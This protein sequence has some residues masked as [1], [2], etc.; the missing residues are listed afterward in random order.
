[1]KV[2]RFTDGDM[3]IGLPVKYWAD[4]IDDLAWGQ[5]RQLATLPFAFHHIA[6]MADCHS[7]YG[8]PIG[9]V[10]AADN[11]IVPNAVGVDIG[12]GMRA[13]KTSLLWEDVK[14]YD[15]KKILNS[16]RQLIPVGKGQH[17][18]SPVEKEFL[19]RLHH[20]H[21]IPVVR[22][23]FESARHQFGTL[24]SGN[25]FI[26]IQKGNDG[27][28]WVMLHSGS[29]NVGY[30]VAQ[31]YNQLAQNLNDAWYSSVPKE[32]QLA[33]L[34]LSSEAAYD[35]KNEMEW[36]IEFAEASRKCMMSIIR[37][38]FMIKWP[39]ISF[40]D[41]IDVKHNYARMEHH[42]GRNVMVHRKGAI[43]VQAGEVGI[44]PGSQGTKSYIVHGLGN[45]DS[46]MSA[47]HGAGR[48]MSRSKAKQTLDLEA[49]KSQM[50]AKGIL[51]TVTGTSNLDEAPG[52]YK[53]IDEVM[54]NQQDLVKIEIELQPIAVIKG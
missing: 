16:I 17:R 42:F 19:P 8:M 14:D 15:W 47:S 43:R 6:L 3:Q 33:F 44:I 39:D 9:G 52:A 20:N 49:E 2:H 12:C 29:R 23:E 45:P 51:H 13:V 50:D 5:A 11:V 4:D 36:C 37:A 34:P 40:D 1:M 24:G 7:G 30:K 18:I 22:D 41:D 10:L 31:F 46:F 32:S 25:H 53:D 28:V 27:H 35:Y 21:N 54:L 38:L 26:E 48:R